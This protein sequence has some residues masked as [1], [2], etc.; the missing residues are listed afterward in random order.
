MGHFSTLVFFKSNISL[1]NGMVDLKIRKYDF[2][3]I[4]LSYIHA[5]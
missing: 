5:F 4:M 3:E 1:V 2:S